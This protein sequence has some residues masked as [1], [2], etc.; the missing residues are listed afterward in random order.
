MLTTFTSASVSCKGSFRTDTCNTSEG[1][2]SISHNTLLWPTAWIV[3]NARV[4]TGFTHASHLRRTIYVNSAFRVLKFNGWKNKGE[5]MH[6][7]SDSVWCIY[8]T[9]VLHKLHNHRLSVE[10][11][12]NRFLCGC[13]LCNQLQKHSFLDCKEVDILFLWNCY[14]GQSHI[15]HHQHSQYPDCNQPQCK[16]LGDCPE[17]QEDMYRS[18]CDNLLHTPL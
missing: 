18:E 4:S 1:G 17:V 11:Y 16:P 9:Y 14:L 7:K 6:S 15:F 8:S 13:W 12:T 5:H 2:E 3:N 10:A